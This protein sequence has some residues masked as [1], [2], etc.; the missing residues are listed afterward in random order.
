M[1]PETLKNFNSF[2]KRITQ[3]IREWASISTI[4]GIS[5]IANSKYVLLKILW[6]CLVLI[7]FSFLM[8][9][10]IESILSFFKFE[11]DTNIKIIREM[12]TTFPVI[13][14][15]NINGARYRTDFRDKFSNSYLINNSLLE[16]RIS[17]YRSIESFRN[18]FN[19]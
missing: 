9:I 14:F 15:C 6:S 7:S 11:V 1:S 18:Y 13:T 5:K 19:I 12:P 4:H 2:L 17:S 8:M 16:N 3:S 10:L